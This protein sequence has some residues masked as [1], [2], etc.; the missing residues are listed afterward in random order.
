MGTCEICGRKSEYI[1]SFLKLCRECIVN[2]PHKALEI[3]NKRHK[4]SRQ[5]FSL[6]YPPPSQ[7][8]ECGLCGNE[9]RF[10]KDTLVSAD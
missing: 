10:L 9:L 6:P 8:V 5:P 1:S 3:S 2:N 4:E 7:G